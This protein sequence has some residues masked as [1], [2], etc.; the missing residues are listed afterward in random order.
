[1]NG[2]VGARLDAW[3]RPRPWAADT[4]LAAV[5]GIVLAPASLSLVPDASWPT[6]GR[7]AVAAV[8][9]ALHGTVALRR[10]APLIACGAACLAMLVLVTLPDVAMTG[11]DGTAQPVPPV[12]LPSSLVWPVTL[13]AVAAYGRR[14]WPLAALGTGLAGAAL[15]AFRLMMPGSWVTG[16]LQPV[17]GNWR[18]F[19]A[20]ALLA[21]VL[22]PWGL[23]RLQG[24]RTAYAQESRERSRR[25]AAERARNAVA[26]ERARIARE[27]HDVVA[28]SLAVMV[29]LA[30][31]GRFAGAKDPQVAVDALA[32]VADTGRQALG[33][34][35]AVMAALRQDAPGV[36]GRTADTAAT[37]ETGAARA[38]RATDGLAPQPG[39]DDLGALV[40]R[41]RGTGLDVRL[42]T[43]GGPRTLDRVASLAAYRV[44]QES[45]TNAVKHAGPA[46]SVEVGVAWLDH[47]VVVTVTDDG[48]T[49]VRQDAVEAGDGPGGSGGLG[50]LGMHERVSLAGGRLTTGRR[51]DGAPGFAVRARLPYAHEPRYPYDEG[52]T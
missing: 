34:M 20:A 3:L 19:V 42:R 22:A 37:T 33:D 52:A 32:T 43:E 21:A 28:H 24:V 41:V 45:L 4:A 26:Q 5:L 44:V 12:L 25:E 29:R 48:A 23:G 30:E 2:T 49:P 38:A 15:A 11:T 40:D 10:Q 1:V 14:A 16:E 9:I 36:S 50:L 39:V 18:L 6:A 46:A 31:G 13:H 35:R 17:D 8:L 47:E 7:L 51:D 27:M